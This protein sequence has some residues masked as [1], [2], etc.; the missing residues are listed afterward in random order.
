[1]TNDTSFNSKSNP[2]SSIMEPI[3]ETPSLI[4]T[5]DLQ[6]ALNSNSDCEDDMFVPNHHHNG[7][8]SSNSSAQYSATIKNQT[9]ERFLATKMKITSISSNED[10]Y[11]IGTSPERKM[12]SP[13]AKKDQFQHTVD[14]LK[15]I[16]IHYEKSFLLLDGCEELRVNTPEIFAKRLGC[17]LDSKMKVV[18][19]FG[20][21]G[22]GKS[23]TMNHI[24]FDGEEIFR[25]SPSQVSCT[26][27][28][29]AAYQPTLGILCLDTEGLLGATTNG[30][31]RMRLLLKVLAIS[32]IAIYRTRSERLHR[33]LFTFLGTASKAFYKHFSG[34]LQ[35][36]GL[37]G[38]PTSLGPAVFVFHETLNTQ[39]IKS[40]V[41]KSPEDILRERFA[42]MNIDL[43]AFSSL[44][45]IGI[46]TQQPPTDYSAIKNALQ[47]EIENTAVRSPRQPDVIFKAIDG[48]N[49]KFSGKI[50]EKSFNP[51]PEQY[52]TCGVHCES[53][54]ARC[55][56]SMGHVLEGRSHSNSKCCRYQKQY[57]NNVYLCK[58]CHL[59]GR[60][61][62]VK[63][64]T[65]TTNDTSWFGLAKYA[66]SGSV[67][68]CPNCG[69]LYR[70]RQYWYGNKNPED[71][72]VRS[73]IVHVWK[74]T[75]FTGDGPTH[76]AQMVID[77]VSYL[78]ETVYNIGA[79]PSKALTDWV[80][81]WAAPSYWKPN[82]EIIY[83]HGCKINFDQTGLHKHHCRAC[84][85]GF[86]NPCSMNQ[87]P[88]PARG[89]TSPVRVCNSCKDIL[90]K[91]RDARP[92]AYNHGV[93]AMTDDQDIRVRKYGEVVYNTLTSVASVLEYPKD[94][95]KDS[96]R[97]SYWVPDHDREANFC[98]V[99]T[100]PFG[101]AEEL[102]SFARKQASNSAQ[103]E[104]VDSNEMLGSSSNLCDRRRHHCRS[105]GQAVCDFC[106]QNRM[107][108]P[109]RGWVTDVRVCDTCNKKSPIS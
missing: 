20:N 97:P 6:D 15:S 88:V 107:P 47:L 13:L 8:S 100:K 54:D 99:C 32:D 66:W 57:E 93:N 83:C 36:L 74:D 16:N 70:S 38:P 42:E 77:G 31:Q 109:E 50:V 49:L 14:E 28:V 79:Q 102:T 90:S 85:E 75:K 55:E 60:Q 69:E 62:I 72:A 29:W 34:A 40:T 35:S 103:P 106:S 25:T 7:R 67:I 19:I 27:G 3:D 65:Q 82:A 73:E 2:P 108:V 56:L 58:H 51:F 105:C 91:K 11:L 78:S 94:L 45:Y 80:A 52:F 71:N 101:T 61:T 84:G 86:C 26:L 30:D 64:T 53:C 22:D 37:P 44:R 21:T 98:C 87:I 33:D 59:N 95:I 81:D 9:S 17:T 92:G 96:A 18:S 1:M 10:D 23:H 39:T 41:D 68:E 5:A 46:Q 24:F 4:S 104:L 76:S 43:E 48:L 89:W 63:I 12:L